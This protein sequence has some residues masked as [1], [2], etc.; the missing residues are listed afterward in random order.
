VVR[1]GGPG[2]AAAAR[3][4]SRSDGGR[5]WRVVPSRDGAVSLTHQ[6]PF[7]SRAELIALEIDKHAR[8]AVDC[9]DF[10]IDPS[11]NGHR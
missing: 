7:L 5:L 10:A 8:R 3:R 4:V 6:R 1:P 11:K 2:I 9:Q